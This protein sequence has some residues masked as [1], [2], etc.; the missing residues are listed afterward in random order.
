MKVLA[1]LIWLVAIT[2]VLAG[3]NT[4][5]RDGTNSV[6]SFCLPTHEMDHGQDVRYGSFTIWA[7]RGNA[8]L[9]SA[10]LD[11]TKTE[12]GENLVGT[13]VIPSSL[14]DLA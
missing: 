5:F 7:A 6:I 1:S 4:I 10:T 3:E 13:I 12:D 9:L 8:S 2:P 11:G 14:V